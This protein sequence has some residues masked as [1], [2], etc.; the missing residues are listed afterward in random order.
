MKFLVVQ[1]VVLM[2]FI[3]I[4]TISYAKDVIIKVV[5]IQQTN[6]LQPNFAVLNKEVRCTSSKK[7]MAWLKA[8]GETDFE[9]L[10][11]QI[12]EPTFQVV[13]AITRNKIHGTFTVIET[14]STGKSC[15]VTLGNFEGSLDPNSGERPKKEL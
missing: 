15:M 14:S 2:S 9:Y 3:M 8:V 4:S 13:V 1:L 7:M 11:M 12:P 6:P 10:G 5:P